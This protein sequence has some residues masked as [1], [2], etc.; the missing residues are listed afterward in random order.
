MNQDPVF[1]ISYAHKDHA[2]VARLVDHLR[3]FRLP[4]WFD[5]DLRVGAGFTR[6]IRQRIMGALAV[7]VVMSPA[8]EESEWVEREILEGQRCGRA[9]VP[10][11]LTGDRMFLLSSSHYFDAR[12]GALP[13]DNLIR[14]F[15]DMCDAHGPGTGRRSSLVLPAPVEQPRPA[16]TMR[17]PTDVSL[18][19]LWT[20]LE[21]N[22]IEHADIFTTSMVLDA[23][24]RLDSGWML[25]DQGESLPFGLLAGI[26]AAWS[27]FS[28]GAHGFRAQLSLHR[29]HP[30]DAPAGGHRDFS[31]LALS[32]G[33]KS[34]L[35]GSMPRYENFAT[36]NDHPTGFFPTLRNPQTER[37]TS[38][39]DEWM[40]TVMAVHLRLRKWRG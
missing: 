22:E 12:T 27:K 13:D 26:D 5:G 17:I 19:K 1:F 37:R 35:Y 25:R 29:R 9:F 39:P 30:D 16:P 14:Q 18:Q 15:Q 34:T 32:L 7:I 3:G 36:E 20:F 31:M 40:E 38:W 11:L 21:E 28:Q 8:A 6:E 4:L 2:Y 23:V 24:G 33:W 10:I